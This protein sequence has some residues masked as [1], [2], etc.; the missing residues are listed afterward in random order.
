ME[1]FVARI[2]KQRKVMLRADGMAAVITALVFILVIPDAVHAQ[3]EAQKGATAARVYKYE[4]VSIKRN[5]ASN[6]ILE[7]K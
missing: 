3:A 7:W 4:V 1:R 2:V 6:S 5:K